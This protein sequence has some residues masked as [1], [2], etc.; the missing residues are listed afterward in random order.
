[1]NPR[2]TIITMK[3]LLTCCLCLIICFSALGQ[4][5][6]SN[7]EEEEFEYRHAI[8]LKIS[9]TNIINAIEGDDK[10]VL[11]VPSWALN[12]N[13]LFSER[14][15]LGLHTDIIIETF[16]I[17]DADEVEVEREL[18]WSTA[19]VGTWKFAKNFGI[20]AG[21]GVEWEK[22]RNFGL[23]RFGLDYGFHIP[24]FSIELAGFLNYDILVDGYDAY[25]IGFG[26]TKLLK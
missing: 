19:I 4:E 6:E 12:Y 14:W 24:S 25:S 18:P 20:S 21:G 23:I 10:S 1:M 9:H 8:G 15:A 22:N 17:E 7:H 13:Y 26:I 16:V 11:R 2:K 5:H 3:N